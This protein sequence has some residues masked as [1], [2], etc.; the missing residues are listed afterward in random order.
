MHAR[1]ACNIARA[2]IWNGAA[3]NRSTL[4][5]SIPWPF[6]HLASAVIPSQVHAFQ[7]NF[8]HDRAHTAASMAPIEQP[9]CERSGREASSCGGEL[10]QQRA[11]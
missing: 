9:V 1:N 5:S 3:N 2:C 4:A 8:T 6:L 10:K 11:A 7:Q